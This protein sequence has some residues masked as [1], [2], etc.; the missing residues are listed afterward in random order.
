MFHRAPSSSRWGLL[1]SVRALGSPV[2][3]A[4]LAPSHLLRLHQQLIV[5]KGRVNSAS[6]DSAREEQESWVG[7]CNLYGEPKAHRHL[8]SPDPCQPYPGRFCL[9]PLSCKTS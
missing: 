9:Y 6:Q 4:R 5:W 8:L 2:G 1:F 3:C 7:M